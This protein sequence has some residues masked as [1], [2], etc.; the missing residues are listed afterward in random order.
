MGFRPS[1]QTG[2]N[3]TVFGVSLTRD[4]R[5]ARRWTSGNGVV[6]A[7]DRNKIVHRHRLVKVAFFGDQ[8]RLDG[9]DEAEEFL[10]GDLLNVAD[11]IVSIE[12]T[13]KTY[14]ELCA[15][16][17]DYPEDIYKPHLTLLRHPRLVIDDRRWHPMTG[18]RIAA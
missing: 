15:I 7:L 16:D 18:V 2:Y 6:I 9:K 8:S 3:G 17:E 1:E 11:F 5:F 4:P 12:M 10:V 14:D 13:R